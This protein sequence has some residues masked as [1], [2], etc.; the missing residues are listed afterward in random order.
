MVPSCL[1]ADLY[2]ARPR[3]VGIDEKIIE[4]FVVRKI[5]A[6]QK[7]VLHHA[8]KALVR[9]QQTKEAAEPYSNETYAIQ[10]GITSEENFDESMGYLGRQPAVR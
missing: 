9:E 4:S 1:E 6:S 10:L 2:M 3:I 8:L 5:Y 7:E